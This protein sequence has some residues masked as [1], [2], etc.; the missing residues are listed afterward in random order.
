MTRPSSTPRWRR[1]IR[2][3]Q[4]STTRR[5]QFQTSSKAAVA[6]FAAALLT[7]PFALPAFANG[8][9]QVNPSASRAA[10]QNLSVVGDGAS[11]VSRD[12]YSITRA[13]PSGLQ[14]YAR[15]AD[16]FTNNPNSPIQWPFTRG[17]PISSG[18]GPRVAPCSGCPSYHDG[19]DMTPGIGTPIQAIADGVVS[20]IGN[21][22]GALGVYAVVDHV[23]NGQKVSSLYAHM[24][25]GSL[26]VKVGDR[27]KV[28]DLIGAVGDTGQSTGP[29]LHLGIF[30]D[31]TQ[32]VDPFAWLLK[33]VSP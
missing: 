7:A 29:H 18:F 13:L 1:D 26:S 23:I 5:G 31:G 19:I 27:V 15:T 14:P 32:A 33:E 11:A 3:A 2:R 6:F 20:R 17:V 10:S 12:Q 28:T 21:P 30:L 16:T 22:S 8:F 4:R 9:D 24:L 25:S